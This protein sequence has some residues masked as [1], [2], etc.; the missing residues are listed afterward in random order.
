MSKKRVVLLSLL[1]SAAFF[2]ALLALRLPSGEDVSLRVESRSS[3]AVLQGGDELRTALELL[4]GER[5]DL[6]LA[7]AEELQK[8]PGIGPVLSEA[9]VQYRAEH[10]PFSRIEDIMNVP[11]IGQA[12]FAAIADSITIG[13]AP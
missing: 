5:L 7:S 11:G 10:G 2:A 13:E 4:P 3:D 6:N 12:R 9:I 1:L 8:L